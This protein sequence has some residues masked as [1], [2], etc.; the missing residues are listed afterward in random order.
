MAPC[1]SKGAP[2]RSRSAGAVEE[3]GSASAQPC[4]AGGGRIWL[5]PRKVSVLKITA[6]KNKPTTSPAGLAEGALRGA[7]SSWS[8]RPT[9][10]WDKARG[11]RGAPRG[12][13][14]PRGSRCGRR[15]G[16]AR[17]ETTAARVCPERPLEEER[18]VTEGCQCYSPRVSRPCQFAK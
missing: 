7:G 18:H 15:A 9:R 6:E 8:C 2:K 3:A 17:A 5:I 16:L 13:P 12:S 1:K 14:G 11:L 4:A 10:E